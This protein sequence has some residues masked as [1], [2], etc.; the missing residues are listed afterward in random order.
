MTTP[1]LASV[2]TSFFCSK[3]TLLL[4]MMPAGFV[5]S[6]V[7]NDYGKN[8]AIAGTAVKFNF[9]GN[10]KKCALS[11]D[12]KIVEIVEQNLKQWNRAPLRTH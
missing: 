8:I 10:E 5:R 4:M 2:A 11:S 1:N 6:V 9:S 12:N 3:A 7:W